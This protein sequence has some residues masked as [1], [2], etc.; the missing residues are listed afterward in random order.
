M[1]ATAFAVAFAA[2]S[3][4]KVEACGP[5]G[6][7]TSLCSFVFDV[8]DS[9]GISEVADTLSAPLRALTIVLLAWIANRIIRWTIGRTVTRLASAE[10]LDTLDAIKSK[11]SLDAPEVNSSSLESDRRAQRAHTIGAVLRG[12][13]TVTVWT[14]A[15]VLLLNAFDVDLGPLIA[16]G[17]FLGLAVGFGAQKLIQDFTSGLFMIIEDQFGVGDV[18]DVGDTSGT[19]EGVSLRVTQLR[20]VEGVLWYVPNGE[21][22]RVANKSQ[23]WARAVLDIDVAYD[24]DI[25]MAKQVILD[26]ARTMYDDPQWGGDEIL[27]A[28]EVWG[29]E[30]FGADAVS[31][32]LVVKTAPLDQWVV[33]RELRHRI[34]DAFDA[35]GIEIPF[36]QRTVWIRSDEAIGK[37]STAG[38]P[39][40]SSPARPPV[41]AGR[42]RE[43]SDEG[44]SGSGTE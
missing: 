33:A 30:A 6:E 4:D 15:G 24:T 7:Q 13:S 41:E 35:A 44:A 31:I 37:D 38:P 43:G 1:V 11:T 23:K 12:I 32:R 25:S 29:V 5:E 26:T 18:I 34:K 2:Q 10:T 16:A 42:D 8:T 17:G 27:E 39:A 28:P 36:P 20:D 22:R 40:Q 19:V 21:I 14:I 3:G 9:V